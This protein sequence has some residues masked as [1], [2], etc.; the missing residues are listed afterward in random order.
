MEKT[1]MSFQNQAL[2]H[3]FYSPSNDSRKLCASISTPATMKA[4]SIE[5][6]VHFKSG[7][8]SIYLYQRPA[9]WLLKSF[10]YIKEHL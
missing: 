2:Y 1:Q 10:N 9:E 5:F 3:L 7:L 8:S 6:I 4:L